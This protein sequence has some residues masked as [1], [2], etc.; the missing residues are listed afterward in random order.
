MDDYTYYVPVE[1]DYS[2]A[3]IALAVLTTELERQHRDPGFK[4]T[5]WEVPGP[6]KRDLAV[7]APPGLPAETLEDQMIRLLPERDES[8]PPMTPSVS[9]GS[10]YPPPHVKPR[11][12]TRVARRKP[13]TQ[14]SEPGPLTEEAAE[15]NTASPAPYPD[16]T[17]RKP[18]IGTHYRWNL[19]RAHDFTGENIGKDI[20]QE[21]S[22]LCDA[23]RALPKG[24]KGLPMRNDLSENEDTKDHFINS[25]GILARS[26]EL[27]EWRRDTRLFTEREW[28]YLARTDWEKYPLSKKE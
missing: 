17:N 7:D 27:Q 16:G 28:L 19:Y 12:S 22:T 14:P 6:R 1:R 8:A 3:H 18:G 25:G 4:A 21:I 15:E 23:I 24:L 9:P 2:T 26:S 11:K 20:P 10:T 5:W 13:A